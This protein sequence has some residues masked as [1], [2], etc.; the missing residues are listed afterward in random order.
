LHKLKYS[1]IQQY[2][3]RIT[4][5]GDPYLVVLGIL[6]RVLSAVVVSAVVM[7][8]VVVVIVAVVVEAIFVVFTLQIVLVAIGHLGERRGYACANN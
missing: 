3:A 6:R 8:I 7:A 2:Q 1:N 4:P 5:A